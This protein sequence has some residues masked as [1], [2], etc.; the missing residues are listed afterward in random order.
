MKSSHVKP[1]GKLKLAQGAKGILKMGGVG[2]GKVLVW[3]TITEVWP[4]KTAADTYTS[5][6]QPALQKQYPSSKTYV[7]L[8]DNDPTGNLSKAGVA[9]KD[10]AG[11]SVFRIP[12]RS[13][14]FNVLD[15]AVWAEVERRM[16]RTEREVAPCKRGTRQEF[17]RRLNRTAKQ[18]PTKFIDN[19]IGDM[20]RRCQLLVDVKGGLFEEGGRTRRP[21]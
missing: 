21:L 6:V 20:Q 18:L 3:H 8:E 9:A 14:D 15:Y 4:G 16:R 12:R 11:I 17:E 1:S 5:V 10:A 13:P 19:A 2:G 7:A